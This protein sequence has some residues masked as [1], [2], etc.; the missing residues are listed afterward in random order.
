MRATPWIAAF[1]VAATALLCPTAARG[2]DPDKRPAA[3]PTTALLATPGK[4]DTATLWA[5]SRSLAEAGKA[6]IPALR[7]ALSTATPGQRLAIARAL[8]RVGDETK[9]LEALMGLVKGEGV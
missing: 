1:L 4:A 9:G 2:D 5:L 8:V 7:E 6:A 3:T